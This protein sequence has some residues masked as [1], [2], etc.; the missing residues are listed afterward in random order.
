AGVRDAARAARVDLHV[1]AGDGRVE[2]GARAVASV[3]PSVTGIVCYNDLTAIGVMRGLRSV[4]RPVPED[5][6]LIGF[7]DIEMAAWTD[8]PLTTIRQPTEA[9]GRWAVEQLLSGATEAASVHLE[10]ELVVRG[11]TAP[12]SR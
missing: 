6:S 1:V 3:P 5:V 2:G 10:P 9:M 7:D 11:S 12:P 8:P 4:N